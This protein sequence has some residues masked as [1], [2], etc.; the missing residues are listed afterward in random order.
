[1]SEGPKPH[2]QKS[3]RENT[4]SSA[5]NKTR[6]KCEY[7]NE[8]HNTNSSTR[9]G[10]IRK[11]SNLVQT[12]T[13]EK[14]LIPVLVQSTLREELEVVTTLN[15]RVINGMILNGSSIAGTLNNIVGNVARA[16]G[17][18]L[19]SLP[20]NVKYGVEYFGRSNKFPNTQK[21]LSIIEHGVAA[22]TTGDKA[23]I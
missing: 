15:E 7:H 16:P 14:A 12:K 21:L 4:V 11:S 3:V 9:L 1:M 2:T 8:Y 20:V 22:E 19:V 13:F 17:G 23:E 18:P 5:S 6:E 10:V